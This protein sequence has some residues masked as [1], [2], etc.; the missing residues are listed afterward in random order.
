MCE[1]FTNYLPIASHWFNFAEFARGAKR[2][3]KIQIPWNYKF[4]TFINLGNMC[5]DCDNLV[6][7]TGFSDWNSLPDFGYS[8]SSTFK[9]CTSLRTTDFVFPI[10]FSAGG[11][12]GT[13]S[14]CVNLERD[15]SEF[16]GRNVSSTKK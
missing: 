7:A 6:S 5:I 4:P 10:G 1:C 3:L 8:T 2:L 9:R 16:F 15:I 14:G 13:F 11:M 12:N